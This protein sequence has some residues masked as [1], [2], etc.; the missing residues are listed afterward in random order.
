MTNYFTKWMETNAFIEIT[1]NEVQNFIGKYVIC[2]HELL[3]EIIID[4][5]SQFTSN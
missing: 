1:D 4:N 3:Y 5:G 2:H